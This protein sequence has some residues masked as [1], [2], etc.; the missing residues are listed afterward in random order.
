MDVTAVLKKEDGEEV[1]RQD[2]YRDSTT[3]DNGKSFYLDRNKV[4]EEMW[5]KYHLD[6]YGE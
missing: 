3:V 1:K 4:S 5:G 2:E 6:L